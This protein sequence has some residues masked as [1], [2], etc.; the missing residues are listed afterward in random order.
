M[1]QMSALGHDLSSGGVRPAPRD[2]PINILIVDD[3]PKNLTV[4]EAILNDPRYKLVRAV[5]AQ[6]ALLALVGEDFA[7][8]ILDIRMPGMTGFELAEMIKGRKKTAQVP[9][10]FLT[11]FYN[12]DQHVLTG[13]GTGAVDYLHKPVNAAV[14]RSKVAVFAE[15]YRSRREIEMANRA[16]LAEVEERVRAEE[17]LRELNATLERRVIER[18]Q[19]LADLD[20]RK[21]E[22]LAM[23]GHELRG[24]L[25]PIS[26]ALQ[27]LA[28][29]RES[30][31]AVQQ[32][33]RTIIERQLGNLRHLVDD[34]LE[35]SR[36]TLGRI[37]LHRKRVQVSDI[38]NGAV[39]TVGPLVDQQR[40]ELTVTLPSVP[41]WLDADESRL[42]QVVANLLQN[43][44][45][46]TDEGGHIWLT[47]E[48]Q[49]N[50]A[51]IRVRD[52]GRGIPPD[53]LPRVFD[54]FTQAE[55]SLDR[56]QGGLGIGLALVQQ[57]TQLHGGEV[58]AFSTVGQGSEFVVRLPIAGRDAGRAATPHLQSPPP[59]TSS[60]RIVV[61][62]DNPDTV[63]TFS[64]LLRE[65]GHD[66]HTA[67]D[68]PSALESVREFQP[69]VALLD[70]G[71]PGLNGYGVARQIRQELALNNTV[72]IALTG[73]GQDSDRQAA[74]QAGFNHHLVKP[75]DFSKLEQ[76]LATVRGA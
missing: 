14:L 29:Q 61:A 18:T 9:I 6:E 1:N 7:L 39:E 72:L 59:A 19:T 10:I 17:Q 70:I 12:E 62:D 67:N 15:L 75:A 71:L 41:I 2:G 55:R 30:E 46:Y 43:A 57:F 38:V 53:L 45:K 54:L 64:L 25:A 34:L 33:A 51:V 50:S 35:V 49:G 36:I 69:D 40:H 58:Q 52:T 23:M 21:D 37:P 65:K 26:S 4:L 31:N 11:A 13:Y 47:A 3:E 24:P 22:F 5:S 20:R 66:V 74:L 32:K 73:Y 44:A 63:L 42:E 60:L 68:G 76:I 8:L 56:A 48:L 27:V 16:L 28:L